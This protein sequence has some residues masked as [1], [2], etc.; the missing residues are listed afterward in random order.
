VKSALEAATG[1]AVKAYSC[2]G[3]C[4]YT[5]LIFSAPPGSTGKINKALDGVYPEVNGGFNC[6]DPV[7][8]C[9]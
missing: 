2:Y 7:Y 6:G 5:N 4:E 8:K 1:N 9:S 3:E